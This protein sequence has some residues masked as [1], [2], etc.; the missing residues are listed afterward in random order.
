VTLKTETIKKKFWEELI[1]YFPLI[2]HRPLKKVKMGRGE[3]NKNTQKSDLTS[4]L[5]VSANV[6]YFE[7]R[8]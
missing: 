4:L 5:L 1:T 3:S 7:K 2:R 6:P 8:K